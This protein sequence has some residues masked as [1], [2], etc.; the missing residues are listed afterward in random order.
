ML[1]NGIVIV[2]LFV[3]ILWGSSSHNAN[4]NNPLH[5]PAVCFLLKPLN[6]WSSGKTEQA[7]GMPPKKKMQCFR[8]LVLVSK[9]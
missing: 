3:D 5:L 8:R 7:G 4:E 9:V 6:M 1:M 2:G